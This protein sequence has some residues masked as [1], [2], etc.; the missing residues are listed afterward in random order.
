MLT[1][2]RK[3]CLDRTRLI[4]NEYLQNIPIAD[5]RSAMGYS[6]LNSGKLLRPLLV[7]AASTIF[8]APIENADLP[9]AAVEMMHTYSLIHDD[10]PAMDNADRRR[11]KPTCHK[12]YGDAMAILA[13][14]A[15]QAL[16][17]E[18][19]ASHPAPLS[20]EKRTKMVR[21]LARAAGPFGMV[22]GQ[23]LDISTSIDSILTDKQIR[24]THQLKTGALI[25]ASLE[26]GRLCSDDNEDTNKYLLQEYGDCIGLAF[27]IQDDILDIEKNAEELGKNTGLDQ[28]NLKQTY[29]HLHGIDA[30][31]QTVLELHQKALAASKQLGP[32]ASILNDIAAFLLKRQS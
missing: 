5:L 19:I 17:F 31:K 30:A 7:Y 25:S 6:L 1:E 8:S 23:V 18:V 4:F 20:D 27:Q 14:D 13:G 32:R 12:I 2:L 10:L 29:V 21:V 11:G 24:E 26:L 15:L 9:A 28:Q 16:A 22:G 3:V